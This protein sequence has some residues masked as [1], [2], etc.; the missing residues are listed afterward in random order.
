MTIRKSLR[1][2][3]VMLVR[4]GHLSRQMTRSQMQNK[5]KGPEGGRATAKIKIPSRFSGGLF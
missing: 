1:Y 5:Y 4:T 3:V 2:N